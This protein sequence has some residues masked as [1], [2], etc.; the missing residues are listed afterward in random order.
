MDGLN[1]RVEM[2]VDSI[3][4]L[5]DKSIE[6]IQFGQQ[7][8]DLKMGKILTETWGPGDTNKLTLR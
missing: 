7:K 2:S 8:I 4:E 6:L 5:E 3:C 1:I